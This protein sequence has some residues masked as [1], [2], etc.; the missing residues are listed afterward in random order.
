MR[1][2]KVCTGIVFIFAMLFAFFA[3]PNFISANEAASLYSAEIVDINDV[4]NKYNTVIPSDVPTSDDVNYHS[5]YNAGITCYYNGQI[6]NTCT[7]TRSCC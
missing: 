2:R 4:S 6:D 3:I 1:R 7:I 5:F